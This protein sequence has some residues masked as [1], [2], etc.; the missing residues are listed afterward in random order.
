MIGQQGYQA[1]LSELL[2]VSTGYPNM[3]F[4]DGIGGEETPTTLTRID[5]ILERH[6]GSNRM[7]LLLGTNDSGGGTP[8]GQA[9]YQAN[10]QSLVDTM[11][12]Q[13]KTVRVAKVP[14][15][16]PNAA[17]STRNGLIQGY[18]TAIDNLTDIQPGPDFYAFF[19]DDNG[20]PDTS[21]DYERLSLYYNSL[22][23][24]ALGIRIMSYLWH[25]AVTGGTTLPLVLDRLCNRLVSADC[26]AV[27]PTNQKQNLLETGYPPYVD[28][29]Y[30]LT[31]IPPVLADGVWIRT[32]NEES[33]N[34]A[35]S[36]I[37]FTVDRPVTV[38]VAYDAGASSPPGWLTGDYAITG[39][40]IQTTDPLSPTLNVYSRN[41]TA[42]AV[43][44]LGGNLASGASGADSNYL[45][46]VVPQ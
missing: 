2:T 7:L 5:S 12:A 32:A 31:T 29:T 36:Y 45:V 19:Y 26:L 6:P 25:N 15:V 23:P 42:G 9:I 44:L 22:H 40:T 39:L 4:N 35:A 18:N 3:V 11:T 8:L 28:E 43:S 46:V 30:T 21:D 24:N 16:L 41:F 20:T 38:Y 17:N 10:M 34:T 33:N 1:E 27:S 13:G 14:P 37:D